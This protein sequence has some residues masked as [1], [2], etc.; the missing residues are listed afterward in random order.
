MIQFAADK[1]IEQIKRL[2]VQAFGDSVESAAY[3]LTHCS[4]PGRY[5]D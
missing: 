5:I 4:R 3:F 1:D 2:W